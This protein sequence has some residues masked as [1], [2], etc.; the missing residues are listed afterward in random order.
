[1]T[2][3]TIILLQETRSIQTRT[4]KEYET[5]SMAMDGVVKMYETKLKAMNPTAANITYDVSDLNSYV[6]TM[7][8]IAAL[9]FDPTTRTYSPH[10]REWI[11]ERVFAYLRKVSR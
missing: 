11:K 6:D 9:V 10:D 1:M 3:H 2:Q 5:V 7:A 8:D 4:Y